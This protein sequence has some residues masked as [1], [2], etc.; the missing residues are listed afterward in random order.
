[1]G[2]TVMNLT[3]SALCLV[4]L[5]FYVLQAAELGIDDIIQR[6]DRLYRSQTSYAEIEMDIITPNWQRTIRME[7]WTEGMN[8]TFA[9]ITAPRK[10]AGIATLREATEMWNYF[11]KINKVMKVPP[12][13]MMGSWMG[14]DFTNDDIVKESSLSDDYEA[15]FVPTPN[16]DAYVIALTPRK[17]IAT[18]W[19]RIVLTIRKADLIP[20]EE[21]FYD[22]RGEKMRVMTFSDVQTFDGRKLPAVMELVPHSKEGHKTVIRY[23]NAQFDQALDKE[24]FSLRNLRKRR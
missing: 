6:I 22:E 8:K 17:D 19:G 10:D 3:R 7:M 2:Y 4:L 18:V 9:I 1:M 15:E 16:A 23:L 24:L 11:P 5:G 14:S 21:A 13:M 20:L 12:S